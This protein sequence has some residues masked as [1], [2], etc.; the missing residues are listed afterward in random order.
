MS[1]ESMTIDLT[2]LSIEDALKKV[3]AIGHHLQTTARLLGIEIVGKS[4]T[5]TQT[6]KP[7]ATPSKPAN[8]KPTGKKVGRRSKGGGL[9]L[10]QRVFK[11]IDQAGKA[12]VDNATLLKLLKK[13][14]WKT[15][16]AKPMFSVNQ[17][18]HK[19]KGD[20][21]IERGEDRLL[22]VIGKMDVPGYNTNSDDST[23]DN[24]GFDEALVD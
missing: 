22:R 24:D 10:N 5:T 23:P 8:G 9:S 18:I 7:S 14:G 1:Q 17:S 13:D 11:V 4:P 21:V 12:G 2:G 6:K 15:E 16:S 19:L 3:N 20:G